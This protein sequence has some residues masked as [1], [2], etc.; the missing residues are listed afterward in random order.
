MKTR[1]LSI[2]LAATLLS[3]CVTD[4]AGKDGINKQTIGTVIGG[5]AGALLGSRLGSGKGQLAAVAVGALA[6]AWLGS[7]VGAS[8]DVA[9]RLAIEKESAFA[10]DTAQDGQTMVWENPDSGVSANITPANSRVEE[11]DIILVRNKQVMPP[12]PLVLIG[13]TYE[14]IK[15]ANLRSAPSTDHEIVGGLP[16]GEV[17][18]AVGR[19]QDSD[20]VLVSKD[21]HSIGYVYGQLVQPAAVKKTPEL[22]KAVNLDEIELSENV[23]ADQ[24]TVKAECRT[25]NYDVTIKD[26]QSGHEKFE[27]C[28]GSGGAWEIL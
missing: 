27:A 14:T 12:P 6:G 23:I 20:W 22:R 16:A 7:E 25:I 2:F 26:G 11:R 4:Q 5:L 8:L 18:H 1:I 21:N 19:V 3:S 10:L 24:V 28:K 9:D 17:F 13:E 15:N